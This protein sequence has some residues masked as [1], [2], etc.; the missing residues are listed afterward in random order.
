MTD[1]GE[2]IAPVP[3]Y[4]DDPSANYG[5]DDSGGAPPITLYKAR[6]MPKWA[7]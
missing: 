3:L 7:G 2:G 6:S 5:N 1:R 4:I